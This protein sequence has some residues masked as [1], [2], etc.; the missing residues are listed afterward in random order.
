MQAITTNQLSLFEPSIAPHTLPWKAKEL[1]ARI[2]S[3]HGINPDLRELAKACFLSNSDTYD[4][5]SLKI[6]L[7]C[8]TMP[9]PDKWGMWQPGVKSVAIATANVQCKIPV[10]NKPNLAD[11]IEQGTI[12]V[13]GTPDKGLWQVSEAPAVISAQWAHGI[14]IKRNSEKGGGAGFAILY[15][16]ADGDRFYPTEAPTLRSL[17]TSKGRQGGSGATKIR[18]FNG[19][20]YRDRP[21]LPQEAEA[22]MGWETGST[23]EGINAKGDR[24]A[25]VATHRHKILGNG[26]VPQEIAEILQ[27]A[28]QLLSSDRDLTA[29]FIF[30][31]GG[32]CTQGAI[33]AGFAPIWAIEQDK[34]AA[35]VYRARFP[36]AAVYEADVREVDSNSFDRPDC[37]IWGSPCP[38]FSIAGKRAG[39]DADRGALFFEGLRFLRLLKP[40]MFI[41]EN[42]AG[43]LS[44]DS[45]RTFQRIIAE[46]ASLGYAGT[47]QLRNANRH[48]PQNRQRI[49]CVGILQDF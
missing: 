32:G 49:F 24:Y 34:H 28:K 46:F 9:P 43:L 20:L 48:V 29:G 3:F 2:A 13:K 31:G 47:W 10:P 6:G 26:I 27:G 38:D 23:A 8:R 1:L 44:I 21:L 22:L 19:E 15:R 40:K 7:S 35:A 14:D 12:C 16:A 18:E 37:I 39:L 30:A 25:L 17:A 11:C 42:V 41:F 4:L 45:G 36:D 33:A 5:S